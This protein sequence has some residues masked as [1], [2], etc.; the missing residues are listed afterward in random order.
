MGRLRQRLRADLEAPETE[1]AF[2]TGWISGVLALALAVFGLGAVISLM[3][4]SAFSMPMLRD[5]YGNPWFRFGLHLVLIGAF[6]LALL[7]LVLRQQKIMGFTAISAVLIATLLGGSRAQSHDFIATDYY[8]G[9][10]WFLINLTLLGALFIPLERLVA[11]RAD[12]PVF[13]LAWREDLFY[14]LINSLLVQSLTYLSLTPATQ[15][16]AHTDWGTLRSF[17]ASQPLWLQFL[18]I[19]VVT[20]LTQ[21][22][23]HRVFHRIPA[24]WRFHAVHHSAREMD[25]LPRSPGAVGGGLCPPGGPLLP[26]CWPRFPP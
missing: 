2:G 25:W 26:L 14:C 3:F 19:V 5:Y 22:W 18:E 15:L 23:V 24:L 1:R 16:V 4:P 7:N 17:V 8:L 12:Q 20:D 21:Y 11:Q 10:D 13:R 6:V 9:L